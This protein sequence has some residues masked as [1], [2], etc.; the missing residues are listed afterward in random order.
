MNEGTTEV[1]QDTKIHVRHTTVEGINIEVGPEEGT[2]G[3][4]I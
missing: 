2:S 4:S 1:S 3:P